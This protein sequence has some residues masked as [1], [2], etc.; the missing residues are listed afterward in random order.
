MANDKEITSFNRELAD[1]N[2]DAMSIE[3]L[4]KRL[5]LVVGN[6]AAILGTCGTFD[7]KCTGTFSGD[8]ASF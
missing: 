7:G 3:E 6:V 1:F 8:C 4:E 5:E 2:I